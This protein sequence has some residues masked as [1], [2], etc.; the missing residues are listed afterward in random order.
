MPLRTWGRPRC[1]YVGAGWVT[2]R[3]GIP[4]TEKQSTHFQNLNYLRQT[5]VGGKVPVIVSALAKGENLD[6]SPFRAQSTFPSSWKPC[7]WPIRGEAELGN[8][9][10][11][12]WKISPPLGT[13]HSPPGILDQLQAP[14]L[15]TGKEYQQPPNYCG[16][17][18]LWFQLDPVLKFKLLL[19]AVDERLICS[20][21]QNQQKNENS[22][23]GTLA[24]PPFHD[25]II[26]K[27]HWYILV[28]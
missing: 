7:G 26:Q 14:V 19:D 1:V 18:S 20:F 15:L 22:R 25:G 10:P 28:P 3:S 9:R 6:S 8:G 2:G 16:I 27:V 13:H 23:R 24:T 12:H 5:E 11:I 4:K 21:P 17:N